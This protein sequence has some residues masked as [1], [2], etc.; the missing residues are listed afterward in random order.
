M[1]HD[2]TAHDRP[3]TNVVLGEL[4]IRSA[5]SKTSLTAA[6]VCRLSFLGVLTRQ[7]AHRGAGC[8]AYRDAGSNEGAVRVFDT[9][10]S[11][12][13]QGDTKCVED[14]SNSNATSSSR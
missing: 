8:V 5:I 13:V 11:C 10:Q 9:L 6:A 2:R 12:T 7:C 1:P 14:S 4:R 3:P